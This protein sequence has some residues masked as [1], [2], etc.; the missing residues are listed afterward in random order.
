MGFMGIMFLFALELSC[1]EKQ[2]KSFLMATVWKP[3]SI[4]HVEYELVG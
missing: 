4:V 1:D 3:E 2:Y